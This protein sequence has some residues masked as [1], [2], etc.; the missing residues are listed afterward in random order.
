MKL[1]AIVIALVSLRTLTYAATP[2]PE[3]AAARTRYDNAVAE[4]TRPV[5]EKYAAELQQLKNRA[6]TMKNLELAVA[7]D[8]E[9]KSIGAGGASL[10]S[11]PVATNK[12]SAILPNSTWIP[13][14]DSG[15]YRS[16]SFTADGKI[17]RQPKSGTEP[18]V[19]YE[20]EKDGDTLSFERADG[21]RLKIRFSANRRTFQM[22]DVTYRKSEP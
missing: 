6:M 13:E 12:L 7:I 14:K 18:A 5:R 21:A 10:P 20:I 2:Y 15:Y 8:Q 3:L 11:T 4:A 17:L 16:I 9:L 22:N 1:T 19:G